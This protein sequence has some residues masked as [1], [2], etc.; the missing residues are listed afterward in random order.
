MTAAS[1]PPIMRATK[2]KAKT[3][4]APVNHPVTA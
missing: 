4:A 3:A 2:L 1:I